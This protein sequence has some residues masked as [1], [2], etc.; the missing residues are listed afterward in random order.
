LLSSR[1]SLLPL[2]LLRLLPWRCNTFTSRLLLSGARCTFRLRPFWTTLN[3]L[4]LRRSWTALYSLLLRLLTPLLLLGA[5]L[6]L[7]NALL[8]TPQVCLLSSI[9]GR[10]LNLNRGLR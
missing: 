5:S 10:L 1:R 6:F 4:L 8:L 9:L 7:F 2:L 3:A